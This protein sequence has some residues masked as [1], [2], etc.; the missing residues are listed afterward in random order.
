MLTGI[1]AG[2]ALASFAANSVLCRL[3][4]GGAA[5]DAGS[6]S[7]IRLAS[8]AAALW[9]IVAVRAGGSAQ[10]GGSWLSAGTLFLYA[11]TFSFAYLDL[12]AGAGALILFGSVQASM[13]LGAFRAG[14]RPNMRESAGMLLALGG[15]GYLASPGLAAPSFSGA[16]LMA[17]AGGAW[18]VYSLRGRGAADPLGDTAGNFVRTLPLAI[19]LGLTVLHD[20]RVSA[21]GV[22][23]AVMSGALT[24]GV[25]YMLWYAA[26][27]GLSVTRAAAVQLC[28]P[29]LAAGGG[30]AFLS[31]EISSRLVVGAALILGGVGLALR[32]REERRQGE[33]SSA[34]TP[35]EPCR[36]SGARWSRD[37]PGPEDGDALAPTTTAVRGRSRMGRCRG[38][39]RLLLLTDRGGRRRARPSCEERRSPW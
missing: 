28:V 21:E 3:A 14:D 19:G 18:G 17:I 25:G 5:I 10:P 2:F 20:S 31:E 15:L 6:F 35:G 9:L 29:I 4:L 24:S 34:A 26:L 36:A 27:R 37:G 8:G 32:G 16:L 13:I 7:A 33:V 12:S 1:Y 22:L 30:V 38:T 11:V 39:A 23:L